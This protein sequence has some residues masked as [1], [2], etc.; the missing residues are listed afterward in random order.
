MSLKSQADLI[1]KIQKLLMLSESSN[2]HEAAR[3]TAKVHEL[4][5]R[6]NLDEAA[7]RGA[8]DRGAIQQLEVDYL[9]HIKWSRDWEVRLGGILCEAYFCRMSFNRHWMW[10]LGRPLDTEVTRD[11]FVRVRQVLYDLSF[12]RLTEYGEFQR[13]RHRI[14]Y[15][16]DSNLDLRTL[17][18]GKRSQEYRRGWL[19]GALE[20]VATQIYWQLKESERESNE[21][22]LTGKELVVIR[23]KEIEES[24]FFPKD[25][26]EI[27]DIGEHEFGRK[28]GQ[29]DGLNTSLHRADLGGKD[30]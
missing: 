17:G 21:Q 6:Y 14:L 30:G 4:L 13:T 2:E 26:V 23:G 18:K 9:T 15:G 20:G 5:Q 27:P 28:K 8:K 10:I 19:Q 12:K 25:R 22:G 1:H 3:A 7:V 16:R 11:V 29:S 24:E